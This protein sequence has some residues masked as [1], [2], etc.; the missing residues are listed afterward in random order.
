MKEAGAW[1]FFILTLI[2]SLMFVGILNANTTI[3]IEAFAKKS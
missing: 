1:S 3:G 2:L